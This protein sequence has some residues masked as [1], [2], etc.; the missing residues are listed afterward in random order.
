M[1]RRFSSLAPP[2]GISPSVARALR[3]RR[4][5]EMSGRL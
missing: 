1:R 2:L 5:A 3:A 4:P